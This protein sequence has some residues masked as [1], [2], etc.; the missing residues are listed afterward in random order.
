MKE[1]A[2]APSPLGVWQTMGSGLCILTLLVGLL[3]IFALPYLAYAQEE[4]VMKFHHTSSG[5]TVDDQTRLEEAVP[6][7][8]SA[9]GLDLLQACL[10]AYGGREKLESL[11]SFKLSYPGEKKDGSEDFGVEKFFSRGRLYKTVAGDKERILNGSDCWVQ[12]SQ[13]TWDMAGFRYRAELYSYLVL[14]MPLAAETEH[15]DEVK[16]SRGEESGTDIFYF[17][18]SDSL[19]IAMGVDSEDH[20]IKSTTGVLT[21]GEKTVVFINKFDDFRQV[22]GFLF[23]HRVTN[24]SLGLKMGDLVLGGVEI[25][26]EFP[27]SV[28]LPRPE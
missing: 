7:A 24:Y 1:V 11:K 15:F 25:N 16:F 28:F 12:N 13:Q 6:L 22:D 17:V 4:E 18:K 9:E 20:L 2:V 8:D 26:P 10:E 27:E 23:P 5:P 19:M 14:S 3:G 21:E